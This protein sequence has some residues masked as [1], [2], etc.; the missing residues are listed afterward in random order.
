MN[1][2]KI[3]W[4]HTYKPFEYKCLQLAIVFAANCPVLKMYLTRTSVTNSSG[5][6]LPFGIEN[7]GGVH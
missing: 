3:K 1:S 2:L 5:L 7:G 4:V 6:G